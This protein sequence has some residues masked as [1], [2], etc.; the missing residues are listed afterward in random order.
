MTYSLSSLSEEVASSSLMTFLALRVLSYDESK[1]RRVSERAFMILFGQDNE[2]F[3]IMMF[4]YLDYDSEMIDML[5]AEYT[6]I[7]VKQFRETL[8]LHMGN[9]KN[10]TKSDEHIT[11]SSS[12][13]Y[14][15]HVVDADI[16]PVNDQEPSA[17]VH[18]STKHNVLANEQQHT[19]QSKPSY[20]TYLLEKVDSNTILDSTNKC[21]KG[22]EIDQDAEQDQV[23]SSLLKAEFLKMN[24]MVEK[25]VYNEL[26][27]RF[28]QL[29][30]HCI[31][32]EISIQQKEESFQSNK[33]YQN[34]K[35]GKHGE[36]RK[37][38][39]QLQWIKK[40]KLKKIQKERPE[41]QNPRSYID[42]RRKEGLLL[43]FLESSIKGGSSAI[44]YKIY[45]S[46][47]RYAIK[48][49]PSCGTLY[50]RDC[51]CSIENVEDK[52]LAPKPPKNY[53]RCARCGY[54]VDGPNCQGCSLLR[55][56]L[57]EYLVTHALDF[58]NTFKPSNASTNVVNAPRE[59]YVVKQDHG[60][61]VDKIIFNL[62]SAPDSPHLYII[63]PNQFRCFHCKDVLGDGKACKL[64]TCV[65]C[66]SG[67]GKGLCY[68]CGNNQNS[69]NDSPSIYETS[70]HSPPHINHCCYECGD[71][72]DGI[73]CKRC[74]CM[75]CGK[76]AHIG[77][78][79]SPIV[80]VSSNPEP[81]N[82]QTI[83][84][85]PQTLPSFHPTFHSEAES[86]FTLP[87]LMNLL[88]F[89]THLHNLLCIL[90]NFTGTILIMVTIVYLKLRLSIRSRVTIKTLIS[91]KIFKMFHNN[92]LVVTITR[93]LMKFTNLNS[94]LAKITEQ[95]TSITSLC[96][97]ACQVVQKKLEEKQL[98]EEQ[99]AKTKYWK[100]PVCYYDDDDEERSDS[101]DDNIISGLPS[102]FAITLNEPVLS[103]EEHVNSLKFSLIDDDSFSLDNIDYVEASLPDSELV[104]SE[105][106]EMVIPE[107]YFYEFTDELIPF[108]SLPEYDCF[109][110]KVEPNSGDFTKDVV[111]DISPTKE[112]QVLNALP[113]HPT[114]QLNMK[115]QPSSE[116][117]FTYVVWIF[118]PFLVYSVAPY[119]LLSL[120]NEDT[121]FDPG[122][123]NSHFL[124][125][126]YLIGERTP[127]KDKIES[128]PDKNEKR[129]EAE[130]SQKQLQWIKKEK[131][132][133]IQK[134]GPEMQN[135][136][137]YID[138]R[139]KE[140]LLLQFLESSIKGGNYAILYK[141]FINV[142]YMILSNPYYLELTPSFNSILRAFASL[143]H[144]LG[145]SYAYD[146][147]PNSFDFPPDSYHPPHP[148]Y[149][150][151]SYDSYGN[152]SQF[153]YDFQPQFLLNYESEQGYIE[154]Y[155]FYPYDS[156]SL[157]QQYPCC[158]RCGDPLKTFQC[159]QL[160]FDGPYY[161]FEDLSES[162]EEFSSTD[163]DSF[164]FDK[165]DYV[166]A[167][168][169]DSELVSS[170][171]KASNDNPTPFY[172]PIIS[173]TPMTLTPSGESDF[174]LEVDAFLAVKDEPTSSQFPKSYLDPEGDMLL[175][176][177]FLND[178]HSSDFK[179]NDDQSCSNEDVLEKIVSKPLFEEEIISMKIDQHPDNAES[180][181]ME[182][183]RTNDSS[184]LIS[185]K[186]DSLLYEFASELTLLKSIPPGIDETD[187]DFEED[188]R[189][190]K[191]LLYD[192]SSPRPSKE[193]VSTNSD[194][195]IKSFSP[196]PI[197]VKDSDSLIEEIDLTFTPD[198]PI[199]LGIVDEDY[200]FETDILI[201]KDLPSNNTLLF[202]EKESFHFDI[203]PFSRP[204]TKPPDGDTRILNIK[205]M[206]DIFD[207][208]AF[209]HKLMITLASHQEK[210]PDL[211][212]HRG[213]KA[214]HPSAQC[215]M[216][217]HG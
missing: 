27:N 145:N 109:L 77:Y 86:P 103:T 215:P 116:S 128:K 36:A 193:F 164:S 180:D 181:L 106:M 210:S 21:H 29:E 138:E 72:L 146:P 184:L 47:P 89:S 136:T 68:I 191:K 99:A 93:L 175:L 39:K 96:E 144:D 82:N 67:L 211:L 196:S 161:Q 176:E 74:T 124:G 19:N 75:S 92:I 169:P 182:S 110:F 52:I 22:G 119:Y 105:V 10:G 108:I 56:E 129:G 194:A 147:N 11:S 85:L 199:L 17:E 174:F 42:E 157:P 98:E 30:K 126:M 185:S 51:V 100:L 167:S 6:G 151:Y 162:N 35:K 65:K 203:P 154:N 188:I 123:C 59:R 177:A 33:P 163:D 121:I 87:M 95:M 55:Q 16:K 18:M 152:N 120:R 214:F 37:S 205:M 31:S 135:P 190:I 24:D 111:E 50:T 26:S 216:M 60:S 43:Q 158:T 14:I 141:I 58:Q 66:G 153:G 9:V 13:T 133:K 3:T 113:T 166:K 71:P 160:I 88:T 173:G 179:T 64:C 202:A 127:K 159:D 132:K 61:F 34:R 63:S 139:R 20:D 183:L 134:E 78:N 114:V 165:I 1:S 79:C 40:E 101:L 142:V 178:D 212:S 206:G 209:M 5:F 102:F 208:K 213:L 201:R 140:G 204:L 70:L 12:G 57:K 122:I 45:R 97:M 156:S 28:L 198:Y 41:M 104:S 25:E 4:L 207:Q 62:N 80:L 107:E 131:L 48:E 118:L 195:E 23:K 172:D 189:L 200:D 168:P 155:N 187:C 217:I 69:L 81:C 197:L 38:Q 32:L 94:T 53:A 186:I 171:I 44:L 7:K 117:L 112:P 91:R 49:C 149:E 15:T 192:N 83:D 125:R 46:N 90:V 130:K 137:S 54:L 148:T 170:E 115:F 8:L 143:G 2:T 76:D 150:T 73:F 84:E